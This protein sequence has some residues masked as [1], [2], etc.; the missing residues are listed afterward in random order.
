[1]DKFVGVILCEMTN[2]GLRCVR[3]LFMCLNLLFGLVMIWL[4]CYNIKLDKYMLRKCDFEEGQ[5]RLLVKNALIYDSADRAFVRGNMLCAGERIAAIELGGDAALE[6]DAILDADGGYLV[7]GLVDIH[8]HGRAGHDF[9]DAEGSEIQKMK[10]SYL[11]CGVTTV[12][13]TLASATLSDW[14]AAAERIGAHSAGAG[15]RLMG[16]HLEGRYLNPSKRG[17]QAAEL[18]VPPSADELDSLLSHMGL[19]LHVSYA[20][21]TDRD[22]SFAAYA[23]ERGVTLSAGHTAMT[24]AEAKLA[25][26][27]GVRAYTHLFN[28]MN[29]LHHREGGAVCAALEGESYCE[30]I[31]DGMH[32]SP[33]VVRLAYKCKGAERLALVSDSMA[34]AGMP[35]GEYMIAGARVCVRDGRA[36]DAD[37]HLGGSTLDMFDALKNLMKFC[38]LSL[39]SA[40][41]CATLTPA[42]L[43]GIDGAVGSLEVG[44]FAD[45]LLLR[46]RGG[47]WQIQKTIIGGLDASML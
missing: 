15:A 10:V 46:Q 22:G 24:Y 11:G 29:P 31:C 41:P 1:M 45:A 9:C 14:T 12:V 34:G 44:K 47:E 4:M 20:P 6:Y 35:D 39:E 27:R 5:M 28:A 19:L 42:R 21:E 43:V 13:P 38:S 3:G 18:L 40:L 16:L 17:V 26:S 23:V 36:L 7:P 37:G 8:T 25:E 2:V 30:L 32:I 33:G